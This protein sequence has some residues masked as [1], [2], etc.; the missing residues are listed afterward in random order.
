MDYRTLGRTGV[1][2]SALAMGTDNF[3]DTPNNMAPTPADEA[4]RILNRAIDE[5]INL[6]DSGDVY[7]SEGIVGRT[8]KENGRREHVL[9]ATKVDHN[10]RGLHANDHGHSRLNIIRAC[11]T[12]LRN[13]QTDYI[14]LYQL[15][16]WSPDIP[17]EEQLAALDDLVRQGKVRYVGTS[18][19]PAWAVMESIMVSE[20]KGTVRFISEQPPYN[21]LD[22]RIENELVPLCQKH[23]LGILTWAPMAHGVLAGRYSDADSLPEGSRGALRGSFY[24]DRI[25]PRGVEVGRKFSSLAEQAGLTAAQLA[26]LWVKDQPG[27]TAPLIGVRSIEQ[28][29]PLLAVKDMSL[30]EGLRAACDD[31][32]PPGSAVANFHNTADWMKM[33][34]AEA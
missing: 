28:F 33:Q 4:A 18:T 1:K 13:L 21:L 7:E 15:H 19:H 29:E 6:F 25:T 11:E 23:G 14:D 3:S 24:A 8:L 10:K 12:S 2:V 20:L 34:V 31:L 32:V 9:I 16:R 26:V 30:D 22:R 17:W 27:I 5:G